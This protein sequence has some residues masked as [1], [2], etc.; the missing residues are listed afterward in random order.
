MGK[1]DGNQK[2]A[3]EFRSIPPLIPMKLSPP[4]LCTIPKEMR[5]T[6]SYELHRFSNVQQHQE[7]NTSLTNTSPG[8][9][10]PSSSAI[11]HTIANTSSTIVNTRKRKSENTNRELIDMVKKQLEQLN[12]TLAAL[13][14]NN[15]CDSDM[16][17]GQEVTPPNDRI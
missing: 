12:K 3:E 4:P 1:M 2:D 10:L 9:C 5:S 6:N 15:D 16:T 7:Y 14:R 17:Q 11:H 13:E 8:Q